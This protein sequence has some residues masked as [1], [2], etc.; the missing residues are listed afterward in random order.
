MAWRPAEDGQ[1]DDEWLPWG[2]RRRL[3]RRELLPRLRADPRPG[4][5]VA[6]ARVPAVL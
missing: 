1:P 6:H 5:R 3:R 2:N 4:G